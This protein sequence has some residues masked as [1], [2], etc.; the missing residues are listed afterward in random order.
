MSEQ[1]LDFVDGLRPS[2]VHV[3]RRQPEGEG[4][5]QAFQGFRPSSRATRICP[6]AFSDVR[7]RQCS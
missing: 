6:L 2:E 1:N 5:L 3:G 4:E 7:P